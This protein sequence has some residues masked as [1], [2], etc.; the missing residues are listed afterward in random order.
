MSFFD[1]N[2]PNNLCGQVKRNP[3][4]KFS[5]V[6]SQRM[7]IIEIFNAKRKL[8]ADICPGVCHFENFSSASFAFLRT[9]L[10]NLRLSNSIFYLWL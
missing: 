1:E 10:Q 2:R 8:N 9:F 3:P 6:Y 7:E 5:H 4:R